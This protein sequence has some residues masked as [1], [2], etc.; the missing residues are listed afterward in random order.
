[1]K[2]LDRTHEAA[3]QLSWALNFSRSGTNS[4]LR[5]EI[6]QAYHNQ[7]TS[8][9]GNDESD[10]YILP[11]DDPTSDE[12]EREDNESDSSVRMD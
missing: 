12:E 8:D 11:V 10:V 4:Q 3:L 2:R 5:E 1:M 9:S 7:N 6:D